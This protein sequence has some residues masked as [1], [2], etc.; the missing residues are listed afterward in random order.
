MNDAIAQ[1]RG[2]GSRACTAMMSCFGNR[3]ERQLAFVRDN[4]DVDLTSCLVH[5]IDDRDRIIGNSRCHLTTREVVR[6]TIAGHGVLAFPHPGALFRKA[7]VLAVGGYRPEAFLT[8]DVDLWNRIADAGYGVLVQPEFLL[9]YRVH[10]N[11]TS[12]SKSRVLCALR[13]VEQCIRARHAGQP[14]PT[15][16]QFLQ[17]RRGAGLLRRLDDER[18]DIGHAAYQ[19]AELLRFEPLSPAGAFDACRVGPPA[20]IVS[21]PA[22]GCV[23]GGP[24]GRAA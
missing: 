15:L 4:P 20:G 19:N 23:A 5:W 2:S 8:E 7:V 21:A 11:S 3:L 1:S 9:R 14:R 13:W 10:S 24:K 18:I 6:K 17:Q 16:E 12:T 22:A